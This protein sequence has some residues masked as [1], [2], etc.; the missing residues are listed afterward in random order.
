M[1]IEIVIKIECKDI[2]LQFNN[3]KRL[4]KNRFQNL[5]NKYIFEKLSL[6]ISKFNI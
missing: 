4:Y 6:K 5:E 1:N 3:R 2:K